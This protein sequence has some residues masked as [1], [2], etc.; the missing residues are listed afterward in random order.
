MKRAYLLVYDDEVGTRKEVR[1]LLDGQPGILHW[2]C[3]L[4]NTFY[5]ISELSAQDLYD[6]FQSFNEKRG[7][8]I[9]SE[10]GSNTQGWLPRRTWRL[11]NEK[12]SE[13]EKRYAS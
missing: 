13:S 11:L 10:V 2:R 12:M 7:S 9:V 4:P 3:D 5:L 8:F 6:V 1:K